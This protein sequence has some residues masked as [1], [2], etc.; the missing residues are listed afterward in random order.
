VNLPAKPRERIICALDTSDLSK[1]RRW[2]RALRGWIRW[3]KVGSEL[4]SAAGTKAIHCVREEGGEVFLDLK[5]HDIPHTV[6]RASEQAAKLGVGMFNVHA[7]GGLDMMRAARRS[8]ARG[9]QSPWILAVTVLTSMKAQTLRG[10]LGIRRPLR[11]QVLHLAGLAEQAGLDGVVASAEEVRLIKQRLGR[12]FRVVTPG[13]RPLWASPD[14]QNR[15][16]TPRGAFEA[17]ADFIV[18]GRPITGAR[19]PQEAAA[20]I[21]AEIE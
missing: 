1:C 6:E 13:I 9:K 18:I 4:F 19:D 11:K 16:V 21:V 7:S 17:G 15:L 5:F 2:V 3:F 12:A 8:V 20:R 10:E 14:D